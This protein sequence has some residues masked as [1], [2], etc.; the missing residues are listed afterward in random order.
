M[1]SQSGPT[2]T[3]SSH[4]PLTLFTFPE[5]VFALRTARYLNLR[6]IPFTQI[7]VPPNMPRPLLSFKLGI[8][9]RRIPILSIGRDIY[10]DTRLIIRKVEATIGDPATRLGAKD[11]FG[12]GIED[13]LEE[14]IIDGGPFWRTAGLIPTDSPLVQDPIWMKDR[15][16]GSGGQFTKEA[17]EE[18]RAW[19]LSQARLYWGMVERMLT[20]GREWM[21]GGEKPGLA[22]IHAAWVF[23][24]GVVMAEG[25]GRYTAKKDVRRDLGEERFPSVWGWVRRFREVCEEA[26]RRNEGVGEM[27]EG[28]EAEDAVVEKILSSQSH[29]GENLAFDEDDGL[30]LKYGQMVSIAPTDFGFT[31]K[32]EGTLVGLT[33]DEAVIE[34]LAPNDGGRLR[35]HY[36]RIN[37]KILPVE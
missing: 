5:S 26:E 24:W 20:D 35:L 30:G 21:L 25:D 36:P 9:Y 34:I 10:I 12:S 2:S 4:P 11:A 33:K 3:N 15:F 1:S 6:S 16:D 14:F 19:N 28:G 23:D 27:K 29:E 8:N 31:H 18:N 13:M 7:R 22:E 32:D 17:L 37:F